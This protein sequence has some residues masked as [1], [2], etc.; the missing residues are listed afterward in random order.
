MLTKKNIAP[1]KTVLYV[2]VAGENI[3]V[4]RRIVAIQDG[5]KIGLISEVGN[6]DLQMVD[7]KFI[8]SSIDEARILI[9]NICRKLNEEITKKEKEIAQIKSLQSHAFLLGE[10]VKGWTY[11]YSGIE[12]IPDCYTARP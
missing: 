6:M 8:A 10:E 7:V 4:Q 5:D 11:D 3:S 1:G 2:S 9:N 12:D